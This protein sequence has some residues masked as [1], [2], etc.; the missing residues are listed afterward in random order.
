MTA[1]GISV[2]STTSAPP[3]VG[4]AP[5]GTWYATGITQKGAIGRP[6]T[7]LSMTDFVAR[8]GNRVAAGPLYDSADVFFRCGGSKMQVSRVTGTSTLAATV[9]LKDGSAANTL[10]V[11]ANSGGAWGNSLTVNVVAGAVAGTY[12]LQVLN[13]GVLVEYSPVLSV[14]SDAVAWSS[15]S[16]Y[17]SISNLLSATA[18]PANNPAVGSFVLA[19]GA[20]DNASIT[21]ATWT[22]ALLA[23][24][25]DMGPGQVSAPGR[26]TTAAYLALNAHAATNNRVAYLD[27][28]DTPTA[29]TLLTAATA[30]VTT[31]GVDGSYSLTFAGWA[32]VPGLPTGTGVPPMPRTVPPSAQAAG[33]TAALD[34]Q[35]YASGICDCNRMPAGNNGINAYAI[36]V[37]QVY[38]D[39]DR[40]ALNAAGINVVRSIAGVVQLFGFRS[41]SADPTWV[42]GNYCRLRMIITDQATQIATNIGQFGEIDAKAQIFGR[43]QGALGGMLASFYLI[44]SLYGSTANNSYKVNVGAGVNTLA[45]I[46]GGNINAVLEIKRSPSAEFVN[47]VIANVP[48]NQPL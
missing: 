23:F 30:V 6:V 19:T 3:T 37:T 27:A 22:Q 14:P 34:N 41:M 13:A 4:S 11:S 21:E 18:A 38:A 20:D 2:I 9:Q 36:G 40:G 39:T 25:K 29:A 17:L 47:I 28:V 44:G 24:T 31:S 32:I 43:L 33:V 5:T 45:S 12:V 10:Q 35:T 7:V 8:L 15:I 26:T 48:L 16:L 42:Q 46:A 1:P